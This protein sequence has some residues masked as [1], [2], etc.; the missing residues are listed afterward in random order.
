MPPFG[1]LLTSYTVNSIGDAVGIVA[2]AVLVY[3]E[4]KD[5]LATTALF[6]AAE[7]LPAFLAPA[8]TAR[9]DQLSLRRVLPAIYLLEAVLFGLLALIAQSFL[10]PAV[11]LITFIDGVF[12]LTARGL[13]RGALNEV[14]TPKKLLP[15]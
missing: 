5:P 1:R 10:L 7:F 11:L 4:T 15:R 8:V 9:V 2:L 3:A 14:L 6:I 12:M 13:T